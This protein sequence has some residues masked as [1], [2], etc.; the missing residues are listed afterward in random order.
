MSK[1]S[2]KYLIGG[3]LILAVALGLFASISSDNLTYYRTPGE[4]LASPEKF[5]KER[6]RVMGLIEKGSVTW[7]PAQTKLSFRISE[8]RQQFLTVT[9]IGAKPDM[10]KEGQGVVVEG[11]VE[12]ESGFVANQL[13]VKHSEEYKVDPNDHS[14]NKE[15]YFRSMGAQ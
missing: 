15:K 1:K 9:Y 10:F 6:I 7:E 8:D 12:G 14:Q 5:S 13:L 3:V 2:I 11:K 4:V